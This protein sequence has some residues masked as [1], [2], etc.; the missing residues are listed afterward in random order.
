MKRKFHN[1]TEPEQTKDSSSGSDINGAKTTAGA[2]PGCKTSDG[3]DE[4][5]ADD[6]ADDDDDELERNLFRICSIADSLAKTG[7]VAAS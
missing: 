4:K 2:A 6:D 1:R 3:E 7:C 5:S